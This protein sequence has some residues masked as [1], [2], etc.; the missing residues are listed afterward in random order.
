M[1]ARGVSPLFSAVCYDGETPE[2]MLIL[3]L[4]SNKGRLDFSL[5]LIAAIIFCLPSLAL[6]KALVERTRSGKLS[7][8]K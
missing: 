3:V 1:G 5:L 7:F 6:T 4:I 2:A 8:E